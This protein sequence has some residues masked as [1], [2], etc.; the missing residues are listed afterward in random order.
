MASEGKR[1]C[2]SSKVLPE[3]KSL[4][5]ACAERN[6][7]RSLSRWVRGLVVRE[8]ERELGPQV[9]ERPESAPGAGTSPTKRAP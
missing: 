2:L 7:A 1:V 3:V 6:D 8:I 4:A 9:L 5:R